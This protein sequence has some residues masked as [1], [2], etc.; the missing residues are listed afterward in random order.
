M[1]FG[2]SYYKYLTGFI[3][4][5]LALFLVGKVDYIVVPL[6]KAVGG[7]ALPLIVAL[8]IYYLLRPLV[9]R[10]NLMGLPRIGAVVLSFLLAMG[11]LGGFSYLAGSTIASEFNRLLSD[12]LPGILSK[13]NDLVT[14]ELDAGH[15]DFL[16]STEFI[17]QSTNY[18]QQVAT[19]L[20]E[21]LFSGLLSAVS[22]VTG[23][24]LSPFVLFYF[25]KD[26][27]IF[28]R[29]FL[30]LFPEK[31]RNELKQ[32]L[33]ETDEVLSLFITGQAL[34]SLVVGV[35]MYVGYRIIGLEYALVLALFSMVLAIIP[36][37]GPILGVIPALLVGLSEGLLMVLKVFLTMVVVQQLEGNFITPQI[38]GKR[39]H[40]HPLMIILVILVFGSLFGFVGI[41]L[42][43]PSYAII[44][45]ILGNI[46]R[47]KEKEIL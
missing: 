7:V 38:M 42:A 11:L 3:L 27:R 18:V 34:V 45:V 9:R 30:L 41:L 8:F 39:I 29:N 19:L 35:L 24:L 1:W 31:Y 10:L 6:L 5:L 21:G 4:L 23:L 25:L 36:F 28:V 43:V 16:N 22:I 46:Q 32:T 2:S 12:E 17:S 40:T 13:T 47:I 26:D 37:L 14:R 15:L 44:K 33:R 20:G